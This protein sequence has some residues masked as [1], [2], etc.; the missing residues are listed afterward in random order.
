MTEASRES[1]HHPLFARLYA[2]MS[3]REEQQ[4][5]ADHRREALAGLTG[6]VVEVGAGNGLN[7]GHY[8]DSVTEVLAVEPEVYL[9]QL[10]AQEAERAA[11]PVRVLDGVADRLPA[12]DAEFD[13]AVASLVLCSV[14]DQGRALGELFRVIR[15]GG[16]LR[17]YEHVVAHR[18]RAARAQRAADVIWP[19]LAGGCHASRDTRASIEQAGFVIEA[20]RRFIFAPSPLVFPAAPRILGKARRP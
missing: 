18:P 12:A 10:G 19:H 4:G 7:F 8:P 14:P 11:V 20:E 5:Q 9:R 13:A 16:E 2:R 17:F 6:R 1:V 15:P 3:T